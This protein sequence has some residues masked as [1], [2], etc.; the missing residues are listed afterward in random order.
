MSISRDLA[1]V[2]GEIVRVRSAPFV[3]YGRM[4]IRVEY[5]ESASRTMMALDDIEFTPWEKTLLQRLAL[6]RR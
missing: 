1:T 2:T 5:V 3:R 4:Y 6:V